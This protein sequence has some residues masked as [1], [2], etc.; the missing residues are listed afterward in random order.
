MR[1]QQ[2]LLKCWSTGQDG[3]EAAR[4]AIECL[5]YG[6]IKQTALH[7]DIKLCCPYV[8]FS[9]QQQHHY[10]AIVDFSL[11]PF[12]SPSS[13]LPFLFTSFLLESGLMLSS[14]SFKPEE[15]WEGAGWEEK[16]DTCLPDK[17]RAIYSR[18]IVQSLRNSSFR[19]LGF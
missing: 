17:Q 1:I 15:W 2:T 18:K 16:R 13:P 4:E 6:T 3:E 10:P 12:L 19:L 9:L 8:S 14:Y 5:Y 7:L 11:V